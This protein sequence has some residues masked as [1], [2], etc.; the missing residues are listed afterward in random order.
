MKLFN[1]LLCLLCAGVM[2]S[3]DK[4]GDDVDGVIAVTGVSTKT[5][6]SMLVGGTETL[7]AT[8]TPSDA[9]NKNVTWTSSDEA[10][11]TVDKGVVTAL[12]VGVATITVTTED[13]GKTAA[14]VVTV[15]EV[16]VAVT[17]VTL[18]KNTTSIDLDD[19]QAETL[20]ATIAP[21]DATNKNVAWTSSDEAVAT[22][23]D[24]MLTAVKAGAATITVTTE[25]GGHMAT[26]A[27]TVTNH[28]LV[29]NDT[30]GKLNEQITDAATRTVLKIKGMLNAADLTY[31]CKSLPLLEVLDLSRTNLTEIPDYGL[32]FAKN[33]PNLKTIVLPEG[34]QKIGKSAF[35]G[36]KSLTYINMPASVR[37]LGAQMFSGVISLEQIDGGAIPEGVALIPDGAFSGMTALREVVIPSSVTTISSNVFRYCS[38]LKIVT[39]PSSVVNI[40]DDSGYGGGA[41]F[42]GCTNLE[43]VVVAEGVKTITASMFSLCANLKSVT[44]PSSVTKISKYAFDGCKNLTTI[45]LPAGLK[46]LNEAAFRYSG[47]M[48]ITIPNGVKIIQGRTFEEC[49][50]LRSIQLPASLTEIGLDA[51]KNVSMSVLDIPATIKTLGIG[52]FSEAN[53]QTLICRATI[54][55]KANLTTDS[56]NSGTFYNM[57]KPNVLKVSNPAGYSAWAPFFTEIVALD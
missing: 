56:Y 10:V 7:T 35:S 57:T 3:C 34:L 15:S 2:C 30:A 8:I 43:T 22:V 11:A 50:D 31:I 49:L 14:C 9:T 55:P 46:T 25:E 12:K 40:T 20:T 5:S 21:A 13:G 16:A 41:Q 39:I 38:S 33:S 23:A 32:Q 44:L 24:G 28:A 42:D 37:T 6:T 53:I 19:L 17:G 1:F 4:G 52:A 45:E 27:V 29:T 48:T 18:N 36:H 26:C 51:F 47:L 54:A